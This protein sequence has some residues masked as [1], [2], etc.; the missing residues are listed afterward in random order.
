MEV[1]QEAGYKNVMVM[2]SL[3]RLNYLNKIKRKEDDNRQVLIVTGLHDGP[4]LLQR[5]INDIKKDRETQYL[6][7]LH[8]RSRLAKTGLP[9][10]FNYDNLQLVKGHISEYLAAVSAVIATYSS[11]GYEAYLLGI[12]VRIICLPNK[13]N[14]SPL[15]DLYE[16]GKTDLITVQW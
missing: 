4:A 15:L 13:I 10:K 2:D 3:Y 6:L 14:E 11:V 9:D 16:K 12:P 5:I 8:P 1:Y 7:K